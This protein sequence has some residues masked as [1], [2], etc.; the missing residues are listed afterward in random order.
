M[1]HGQVHLSEVQRHQSNSRYLAVLVSTCCFEWCPPPISAALCLRWRK[2]ISAALAPSIRRMPVSCWESK[3]TSVT[4]D[5]GGVCRSCDS[6]GNSVVMAVG[7]FKTVSFEGFACKGRFCEMVSLPCSHLTQR[8]AFLV[9]RCL[10][11][12]CHWHINTVLN[13]L[14]V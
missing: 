1:L 2:H 12:I 7:T 10:H 9:D 11:D 8:I 3:R 13:S 5:G 4:E 14:H 6:D